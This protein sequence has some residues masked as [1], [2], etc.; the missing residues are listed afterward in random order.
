MNVRHT[1]YYSRRNLAVFRGVAEVVGDLRQTIPSS[2]RRS[3]QQAA[4]QKRSSL[5]DNAKSSSRMESAPKPENSI[6]KGR[7]KGMDQPARHPGGSKLQRRAQTAESTQSASG[8]M[9]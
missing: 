6:E 3:H 4:Q 8:A 5:S 9:H 7:T 2:R 1:P